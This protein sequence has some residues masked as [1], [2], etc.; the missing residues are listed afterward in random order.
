MKFSEIV[1]VAGGLLTGDTSAELKA[2]AALKMGQGKVNMALEKTGTGLSK[3]LGSG[4]FGALNKGAVRVENSNL[5]STAAAI[6]AAVPASYKIA[7]GLA[8]AGLVYV[9]VKRR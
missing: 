6:G 1:S 5:E 7:A 8:L 3:I 2:A 9:L 4:L